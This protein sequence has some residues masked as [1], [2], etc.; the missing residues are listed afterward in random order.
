MTSVLSEGVTQ[1]V[2]SVFLRDRLCVSSI[3]GANLL[4][5]GELGESPAEVENSI[6][7]GTSAGAVACLLD[8]RE[9]EEWSC[10]VLSLLELREC[11]TL[12]STG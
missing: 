7:C 10:D 3:W 8:V 11:L 6:G 4:G 12:V 9:S 1:G 2:M 5:F